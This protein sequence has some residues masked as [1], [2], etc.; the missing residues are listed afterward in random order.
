MNILFIGGHTDDVFLVNMAK[1]LKKDMDVNIDILALNVSKSKQVETANLFNNMNVLPQKFLFDKVP[2]LRRYTKDWS[3][4]KHLEKLLIGHHYDIIHCHYIAGLYAGADFL[5]KYCDKLFFTFWGGE[6]ENSLY[7]GSNYLYRIKLKKII[8]TYVDGIVNTLASSRWI[9]GDKMPKYYRGS[10]GSSSLDCLY[11]L[12]ET[13]SKRESKAYYEMPSDKVA[14]QICYS[15][16]SIHK[17]LEII[18]EIMKH[19]ELKDKIHL[20]A[21]MTRGANKDFTDK[22][23]IAL[24]KSGFTYTLLR[25]RFLTDEEIAK[26]RYSMDV[27][28]Q[29]STYD[30][31]SRS[32]VESLCAGAVVI[33]GNWLNYQTKFK[34][35]D[36]E[37]VGAD[38]MAEAVDILCEYVV[39]P[40]QYNQLKSNNISRGKGK[41][42]WSECIKDWISVY[43]GTAKPMVVDAKSNQKCRSFK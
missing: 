6:Y 9:D 42:L 20:V 32:V 23:E 21:P 30:G 5:K 1:W 12:I 33:Y 16:K 13:T 2:Y 25:D 24:K 10:F 29:L 38:S 37:G 43:N 17:Q 15:G 36:F 19:A 26:L 41:Y 31:Y 39:N 4:C 40:Y 18:D 22:V 3:C 8:H 35:D 7:F 28:L 11:G 27:V 14:V 34:I